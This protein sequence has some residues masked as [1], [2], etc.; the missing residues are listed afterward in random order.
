MARKGRPVVSIELSKQER[1]FLGRLS[2][3]RSAPTYE[4]RRAKA[5]LLMD[6]G[7]G[8]KDIASR[9]GFCSA[10]VGTLRKRFAQIRLEGL[11]DLPRSGPPR[12]IGDDRLQQ[13]IEKTLHSKP[14]AATHWSTRKMAREMGISRDSVSRIWRAF[15][16]KPHRADT[17]QISTD[18]YYVDKVR[19][20]VGLYMSPPE[21]ALVL[22]VDEKS[23]IQALERS[24]PV[25]PMRPGKPE[26][27]TPEYFRHGTV[28]L[29]AALDVKKGEIIGKCY[30]RHRA[31]EFLAFLK[32][33]EAHLAEEV[34]AGKEVHLVL[35]NYCTH[36]SATVSRWLV[37][38][39]HWHLHFTP[40]HASWLNQ[41]ERFFAKITSDAIRRGNFLS[42]ADPQGLI[43]SRLRAL[44]IRR[45]PRPSA[46]SSKILMSTAARSGIT[47]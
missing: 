14:K 2:C 19:D 37:K 43:P 36:K 22:C 1:D 39:P 10:T 34:A 32:E 21:N 5:I 44:A 30:R 31:K 16:L 7:L 46:A 35:D 6:E 8:N 47:V 42:L 9:V 17:F 38:R 12:T 29:F 28:S 25:L 15:G 18:P 13:L 4:V 3:R 40:T 45:F 24:Q 33:I 20:V 23:Q 41:M 27:H 26:G 11:S